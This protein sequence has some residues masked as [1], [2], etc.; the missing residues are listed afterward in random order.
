MQKDPWL[1]VWIGLVLGLALVVWPDSWALW[2]FSFSLGF[3]LGFKWLFRISLFWGAGYF[4]ISFAIKDS[5]YREIQWETPYWIEAKVLRE[6]PY[7]SEVLIQKLN[8]KPIREE[9]RVFS[10]GYFRPGEI[11]TGT[12]EFRPRTSWEENYVLALEMR[13]QQQGRVVWQDSPSVKTGS[14]QQSFRQGLRTRIGSYLASE[15]ETI[16]ALRRAL[17]FGEQFAIP[18]RYWEAFHFLGLSHLLVVSGAH[19]GLLILLLSTIFRWALGR[20][21]KV[22]PT[23][24][25]PFWYHVAVF[26]SVLAFLCVCE[27]RTPILRASSY[28]F[29]GGLLT[30][31]MPFLFRYRWSQRLAMVGI[32]LFFLDPFMVLTKGYA[33]SFSATWAILK[34]LESRPYHSSIFF[35]FVPFAAISSFSSLFALEIIPL[36]PFL[37]LFCM[38]LFFFVLVPLSFVPFFETFIE[39]LLYGFFESL[40][41]WSEF[42]QQYWTLPKRS[43]QWG[44]GLLFGLFVVFQNQG[45]FRLKALLGLL[46]VFYIFLYAPLPSF[47]FH[48]EGE[49]E[50]SVRD[51]GQGDAIFL[52]IEGKKV[53]IDGGRRGPFRQNLWLEYQNQV[54]VWLLTHFDSDHDGYF[55]K[56]AHRLTAAEVWVPHLDHSETGHLLRSF[57][58]SRVRSVHTESPKFCTA[59]YC[60]F[61]R[62]FIRERHPLRVS[63]RS[64]VVLSIKNRRDGRLVALFLGDLPASGERRWLRHIRKETV[65]QESLGYPLPFLHA[66]H[67]GSSTSNHE[68]FIEY[69]KPQIVAVTSGRQNRYTFPKPSVLDR[70][71][72]WGAKI[73]RTDALGSY[74]V[75]FDF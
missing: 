9:L 74:E 41:T 71:E 4:L 32:A 29:V 21:S 42:L 37:N 3:L 51:A 48:R 72:R 12:G 44:L 14:V 68:E 61:S 24:W 54:D 31:F 7:G 52:N 64:S 35:P 38:P 22:C 28:L 27:I 15:H 66:P 39:W 65:G 10:S 56:W 70:F 58:L 18:S 13:R 16:D 25:L 23:R 63:N 19:L 1:E 47:D 59:M 6:T 46:S 11:L 49:L 30:F 36:S 5:P 60:V 8:S 45:R 57:H 62:V 50:I 20:L 17:L 40:V 26:F 55:R 34:Y 69:L 33:F 53:L 75:G 43:H 2:C 73:K 67:H